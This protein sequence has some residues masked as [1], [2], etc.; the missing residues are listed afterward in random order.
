RPG[1]AQRQARLGPRAAGK[2]NA[3]TTPEEFAPERPFPEHPSPS[4]WDE[5]EHVKRLQDLCCTSA[6]DLAPFGRRGLARQRAQ[7]EREH[8]LRGR[9]VE[10]AQWTTNLGWACHEV[11]NRLRLSPRTLRQWHVDLRQQRLRL[12][13]LGRPTCRSSV[14]QRNDVIA[15]I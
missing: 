4:P 5:E 10:L 2:K 9:V 14:G 6:L 12:Q 1:L 7:R 13:P 8:E 11:A 3:R 15:L